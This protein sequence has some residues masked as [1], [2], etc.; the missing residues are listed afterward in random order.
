[1]PADY[2]TTL[3][4]APGRYSPAEIT[5]RFAAERARLLRALDDPRQH[6]DARR[7]LEELHLAYAALRDPASQNEYLCARASGDAVRWLRAMIA[8]SLEGGLIRCSRREEIIR[9]AREFGLSDFQ[10]QLLIAQVQVGD[11]SP[12][13]AKPASTM[14]RTSETQRVWV[15]ATGVGFLAAA[16]F[17]ALVHWL[18]G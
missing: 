9:R 18:A 6:A 14:A 4:L 13:S 1:M 12:A 2:F 16:L 11:D 10:A 8:A 15:R 5:S 7:R 3:G 17:F